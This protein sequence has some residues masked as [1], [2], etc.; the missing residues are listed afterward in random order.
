LR[1]PERL[2]V[3]LQYKVKG[4]EEKESDVKPWLAQTHVTSS[5]QG[6]NEACL[7]MMDLAVSSG[8][9]EVYVTI[10]RPEHPLTKQGGPRVWNS[11]LMR[12]AGG[13]TACT[14]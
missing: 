13:L 7:K 1:G 9:A 14:I 5:R 2:R 12:F 3:K 11:Q 4:S 6:M 8:A 10:F